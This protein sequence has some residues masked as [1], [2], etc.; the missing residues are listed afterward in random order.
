VR[1]LRE[2]ALGVL[3]DDL[4]IFGDD[5]LQSLGVSSVSNFVFFCFF[6]A[7]NTSSNADFSMSSTTLPNI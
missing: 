1:I 6:F 2:V 4:L 5:F 3:L 7:S